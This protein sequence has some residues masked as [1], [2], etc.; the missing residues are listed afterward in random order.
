M[1]AQPLRVDARETWPAGAAMLA[2]AAVLPLLPDGTG[3]PCPLRTLT[4]VPCPLCGLTTSVVATTHGDLGAALAANPGG[5]LVV[6]LAILV[7]VRRSQVLHIPFGLACSAL[8]A[9]WLF[10]LRRFGLV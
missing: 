7:L 5:P 1:R 4:G 2:V 6:A 3:I 10:E 9:L 8:G